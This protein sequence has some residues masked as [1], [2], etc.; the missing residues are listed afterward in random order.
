MS[1][2]SPLLVVLLLFTAC[3]TA[4]SQPQAVE[5]AT[6]VSNAEAAVVAPVIPAD[7]ATPIPS[8]T[9]EPTLVVS[10]VK[11]MGTLT[12]GSEQVVVRLLLVDTASGSLLF[13]AQQVILKVNGETACNDR[14]DSA[15]VYCIVTERPVN[16]MTLKVT[17]LTTGDRCTMTIPT[18]Y[19]S[20]DG[21]KIEAFC[22]YE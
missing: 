21:T 1:K 11:A 12:Q 19:I 6:L 17:N 18:S 3:S 20:P 8:P 9:T 10:G 15:E 16:N 4:P 5:V 13:G 2:F 7:T 14:I 22:A